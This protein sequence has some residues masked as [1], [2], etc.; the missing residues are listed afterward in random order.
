M[1]LVQIKKLQSGN[2]GK[3]DMQ[4]TVLPVSP[5]WAERALIDRAQYDEMYARSITDPEGFW[6][7]VAGRIDW[8]RPF[9]KVKD[10]SWDPDDFRI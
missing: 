6:R 2:L 5:A 1:E 3:Q 8:I 7:K 4:D 10:V 9:T